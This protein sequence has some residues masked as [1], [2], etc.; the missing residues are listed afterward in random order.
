MTDDTAFMEKLET[1]Y[2]EYAPDMSHLPT[3]DQ[4]VSGLRFPES[5]MTVD[6]QVN[7][8]ND[9]IELIEGTWNKY[10][11]KEN[12]L[13]NNQMNN[14]CRFLLTLDYEY[15]IFGAKVLYV[16]KKIVWDVGQSLHFA[17]FIEKY[18]ELLLSNEYG[19]FKI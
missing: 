13:T 9:V 3:A 15:A 10:G 1:L 18:K 16:N 5:D 2:A 7:L 19:K 14:F 11:K 17:S 8:L 6:E 4:I 12:P